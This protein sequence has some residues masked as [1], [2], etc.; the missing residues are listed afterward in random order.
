MV[1]KALDTD[2]EDTV[3]ALRTCYMRGWTEP[4]GDQAIPIGR[5]DAE[6]NLPPGV[7]TKAEPRYRLTS[8]G[9]DVIRGTHVLLVATLVA[10]SL[11][12]VLALVSLFLNLHGGSTEATTSAIV[13]WYGGPA[14]WSPIDLDRVPSEVYSVLAGGVITAIVAWLFFR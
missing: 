8:A 7:F 14:W 11:G 13:G 3:A 9:W 10:A 6:G 4:L 5:L 1:E 12:V 2:D